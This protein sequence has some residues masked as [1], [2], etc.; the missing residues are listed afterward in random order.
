MVSDPQRGLP[1]ELCLSKVMHAVATA[2]PRLGVGPCRNGPQIVCMSATM[3][4]LDAM[5]SW[6]S[7]RLFMT[8]F[9]PVVLSEYAVFAG[10]V[11]KKLSGGQIAAAAAAGAVAS[12]CW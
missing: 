3:G 9:R 2:L 11:F 4:G 5:C 1:L 12:G 7:A 8:N 10:K 6:L